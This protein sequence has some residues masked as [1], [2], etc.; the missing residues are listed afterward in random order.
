M[1]GDQVIALRRVW[2]N[3]VVGPSLP[4]ATVLASRD[5]LA[6]VQAMAAAIPDG[7]TIQFAPEEEIG[8]AW[9]D[10]VAVV[11]DEWVEAEHIIVSKTVLGITGPYVESVAPRMERQVLAGVAIG[12]LRDTPTQSQSGAALDP[13]PSRLVHWIGADRDDVVSGQW[14]PG[15][16]MLHNE[17]THAIA[18]AMRLLV[19][20][21]TALGHRLTRVTDPVVTGGRGERRR[22]ARELPGLRLLELASGA[23]VRDGDPGSVEWSRRWMV[24]GHWRQQPCGPGNSERKLRWIDPYVKGP[25]GLPL[26]VRPTVWRTGPRPS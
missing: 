11:F 7:P 1:N 24:R 10:G 13:L 4:A 5:W 17:T 23:T 18:H 9:P 25:E 6:Y 21:T 16:P 12:P 20:L 2:E 22:I 14:T 15:M 19:S 8:W 3:E 26:D